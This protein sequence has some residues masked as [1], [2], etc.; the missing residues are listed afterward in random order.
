MADKNMEKELPPNAKEEENTA[1][2]EGQAAKQESEEVDSANT[3]SA[4]QESKEAT[5]QA[6]ALTLIRKMKELNKELEEE[7]YTKILKNNQIDDNFSKDNFAVLC[8]HFEYLIGDQIVKLRL[9]NKKYQERF[10]KKTSPKN[11][12]AK[13]KAKFINFTGLKRL[14]IVE[15]TYDSAYK[16]FNKIDSIYDITLENEYD[17]WKATTTSEMKSEQGK[18]TKEDNAKPADPTGG[19]KKRTRKMNKK[20]KANKSRKH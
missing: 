12:A 6:K 18:L 19:N 13:L 15:S 14:P 2:A 17:T 7:I 10:G 9:L 8:E 11:V 1:A 16:K 3:E 20:S 5:E 4:K